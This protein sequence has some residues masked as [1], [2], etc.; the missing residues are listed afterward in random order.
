MQRRSWQKKPVART[1]IQSGN[2]QPKRITKNVRIVVT[3]IV[4][5]TATP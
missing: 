5:V 4:P 2:P 1:Q 3:S